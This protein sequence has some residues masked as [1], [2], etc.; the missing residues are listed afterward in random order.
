MNAIEVENVSK[1]YRISRTNYHTLREDIYELTGRLAR[2]GRDR[3]KAYEP[4]HIW[5]LN[6]V[7]FVVQPG[8]RLGIIGRNGS[9]KTTLLRLLAGITRPTK[10]KV[11]IRGRLGV[12][13]ELMA[14][15]H[16]E[17][18]GREN[19]YLNG[20]IM[21]MG[22]RDIQRR[23]DEIVAFAGLEE[24]IDTPIK[25][26]SSGMQ[27]RLGFAVAAHLEPDILLVDEVLA[28]GDAVFQRKCLQRMEGISSE[29]RTVLFVSHNMAA[30]R[31][32]CQ[33]CLWIDNGSLVRSGATSSIV[34]SYLKSGH[35]DNNAPECQFAENPQKNFQLLSA[36]LMN[37][38]GILT[39]WFTCDNPII[40]ELLCK[41]RV[42]VPGLRG[43][44]VISRQDGVRV[45]ESDSLDVASNKLDGLHPGNYSIR[46]TVPARTLAPG[47][48]NLFFN[49]ISPFS[50]KG[51][52]VD[53]PGILFSFRLDDN[54]T[55]RGN[56]RGGFFSTK[57]PW[58]LTSL[59]LEEASMNI[60]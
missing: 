19:V 58:E 24:F 11:T 46:V 31:E 10:G 45:I 48:Y 27:V 32:L 52:V 37:E 6:D 8:E 56:N 2:F 57:L 55:Q 34:D 54:T 36:K 42:P 25:R 51:L 28:V 43:F 1:R 5:A 23:F 30:I 60:D 17:L 15:F 33:T 16:N 21:G 39:Q 20:A 14:G 18:T 7:S 53:N 44:M 12:L 47:D 49:F 38:Q 26:Y 9:G 35:T 50:R 40:I 41:V 13:I 29:G 3:A 4:G 22:R 59:G